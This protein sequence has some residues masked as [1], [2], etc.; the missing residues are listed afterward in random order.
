MT[1]ETS[2]DRRGFLKVVGVAGA[3]AAAP[4]SAALAQTQDH[5]AHGPT[6][7]SAAA[8]ADRMSGW[9]F[10]NPDEAT[11]VRAALDTLIP[12]DATGPGA[13][14]AGCATYM[15]RQLAGA[16]GRG[17][18]LYLQGPFAQGTP[19]QGYQ[20]PLTPAE[21]IRLGIA[22]VNAY[23]R[24]T[25][26]KLFRDLAPADR[27]A[28]MTEVETGKAELANVPAATWFNLFLNL[29]MEGYF[30]DPMY[31][32]NKDKAVWKMIGFPG[33]PGMYSEIIE[34]YRNKPYPHTPKSIQDF[35]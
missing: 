24:K 1:D 21:L 33:V 11:F 27:A 10:F 3:G 26:Q 7:A 35:A 29:T 19:Q 4:A 34:Q 15:D 32:G 14:E 16:F 30:G 5:S 8:A 17:A 12:A 23:A 22:D 18:R 2:L 9:M 20:L 31:G 28:I 25:K 6:P 13:V